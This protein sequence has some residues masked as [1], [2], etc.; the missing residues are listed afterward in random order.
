M[1]AAAIAAAA[2]PIVGGLVGHVM[3][4]GDRNK[5]KKAMKKALAELEAVGYPPDLSKEIIFQQ[6]ESA[7]V[8]TP[9]LEEDLVLVSSEFETLKEDPTLRQNQLEALN[10]FKQQSETGLGAEERAAFNQ[11]QQAVRQDQRAKQEQILADAQRR[12]QG[13]SGNALIAQLQASQAG[14]D[15][16]SSQGNELAALIAQRVRQGTQD[17]SGAAQNLRTQDYNV[18][19]DRARA[20]DARNQYLHQNSSARQARNVGTLNDAQRYNLSND[21]RLLDA[22]TEMSNQEKLRQ[23]NA[24]RN[25]FND[26]LD[27][28]TAK[29]NART[30]QA[31]Q[32]RSE[33][34]RTAQM[35]SGIGQGVG[36]G[37]A[38]YYQGKQNQDNLDRTYE[39]EKYKAETARRNGGR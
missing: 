35:Y 30:G 20:L 8:L 21:Q 18:A 2:A 33:A 15:Q 13:G 5:A 4:Q 6:F 32:H 14:A 3:S 24:Q 12:G 26:K 37:V 10:K 11:I 29:A 23:V 39:L 7:G 34:D 31:T 16:A 25:Y 9:E 28:A 38:G 1:A 19:S 36:E 17:M 22:N 27:L